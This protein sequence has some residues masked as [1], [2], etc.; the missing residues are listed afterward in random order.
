M[1][2]WVCPAGEKMDCFWDPR[3]ARLFYILTSEMK[4]RGLD[5]N[6]NILNPEPV[7][8]KKRKGECGYEAAGMGATC[9]LAPWM[10]RSAERVAAG[11]ARYQTSEAESVDRKRQSSDL[12][13]ASYALRLRRPKSISPLPSPGNRPR[14]KTHIPSS[15]AHTCAE[16]E[17][18]RVG[19]DRTQSRR[20][21]VICARPRCSPSDHS[22]HI[23]AESVSRL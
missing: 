18:E 12:S 19:G 16:R 8:H 7:G 11:F 4:K 21:T 15:G 10:V 9:A 22:C 2:V 5:Q 20:S 14:H 3:D 17:T 23:W 6:A 13:I 1:C